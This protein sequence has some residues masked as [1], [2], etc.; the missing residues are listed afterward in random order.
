MAI[1][2]GDVEFRYSTKV[3]SAGDSTASTGDGSL[4][5]YMSTTVQGATLFD[6]ISAAENAASTVDYRC[7][8]LL[9]KHATLTLK[10]TVVYISAE[11]AGGASV[12]VSIDGVAASAKGSG[13]AQAALVANETTAPTGVGAFSS[14]T[15][16]GAGLSLGD[17]PAASCRAF[18]VRRTAANTAAVADGATFGW[19]AETDA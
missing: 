7:L 5:K 12:A 11:V 16:A 13:S 15:T 2:A 9:N 8:F 10:S 6:D 3:G 18:W 4:G 1:V 19:A 14:P 17:I